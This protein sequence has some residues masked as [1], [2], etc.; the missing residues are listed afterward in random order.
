[1]EKK[2]HTITIGHKCDG[3]YYSDS[4]ID[5]YGTNQ[6]EAFGILIAR[7]ATTLQANQFRD[8]NVE[9]KIDIK[10]RML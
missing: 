3:Y 4:D 7:L 5:V 9:Y 6:L 10:K 2:K 8:E 1:M